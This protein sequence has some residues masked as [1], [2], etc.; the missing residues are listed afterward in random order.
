[1]FDESSMSRARFWHAAAA[2][3]DRVVIAGGGIAGIEALLALH[4]RGVLVIT[5]DAPERMNALDQAMKRRSIYF[6]IKRSQLVPMMTS[7]SSVS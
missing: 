2:I 1:M 4:D 5:F 7:F 3:A 6:Q